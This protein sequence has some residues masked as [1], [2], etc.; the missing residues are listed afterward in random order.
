M[1]FKNERFSR[2]QGLQHL[3]CPTHAEPCRGGNAPQP[4]RQ[5]HFLLFTER[6]QQLLQLHQLLGQN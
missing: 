5:V 3:T 1:F 4:T 2:G 6:A